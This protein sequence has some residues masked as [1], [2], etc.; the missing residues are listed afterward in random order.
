MYILHHYYIIYESVDDVSRMCLSEKPENTTAGDNFTVI[1]DGAFIS[2]CRE[3]M[4]Q[5]LKTASC[6]KGLSRIDE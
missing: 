3:N 1:S 2:N 6:M 4:I 5:K